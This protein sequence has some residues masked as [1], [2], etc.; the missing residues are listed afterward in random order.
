MARRARIELLLGREVHDVNGKRA[1]HIEEII[2]EKRVNDYVITE[3]HLGRQALMERL[4]IASISSDVIGLFGAS[5]HAASHR[6]RWDQMDLTDPDKPRLR[7]R[8]DELEEL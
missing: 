3:Y 7:C 4:S 6:A 2:A 1:G 8:F 5:N